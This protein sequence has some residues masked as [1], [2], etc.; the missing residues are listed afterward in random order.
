[1]SLKAL[2]LGHLSELVQQS[3]EGHDSKEDCVTCI[4]LVKKYFTSGKR[5]IE[6]INKIVS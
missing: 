3:I 5:E 6:R 1:M 4:R 2:A